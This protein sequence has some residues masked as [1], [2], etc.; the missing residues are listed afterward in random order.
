M[1]IS[2]VCLFS[3]RTDMRTCRMNEFSCGAGSTQCIPVFWKCD[4]EKDCDN[5]EDEVNCGRWTLF[6]LECTWLQLIS[7]TGYSFLNPFEVM[8]I[9]F[10]ILEIL[11]DLKHSQVAIKRSL[12]S[13][14]R[15]SSDVFISPDVCL[16]F[17]D[18][19][20]DAESRRNAVMDLM[21]WD[22]HCEAIW[23]LL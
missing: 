10:S 18:E 5:G 6:G 1:K 3:F 8:R 23:S 12:C 4:G 9:L 2:K 11:W 15:L 14:S 22:N 13:L 17:I 16:L 21:N 7:K 19:H 20:R